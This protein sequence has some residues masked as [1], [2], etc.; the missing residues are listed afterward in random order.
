MEAVEQAIRDRYETLT[1]HLDE[2]ATRLFLGSEAKALGRGGA[3]AV[4][5]ATGASP[6]TVRRG[7]AELSGEL[8]LLDG[9]VR[10]PGAGRKKSEDVQEGLAQALD[11]LIEPT[12]RGDPES[13]L[14]WTSKSTRVLSG[15]LK[16]QGFTVSHE[17]VSQMLSKAGYSLQSNRKV[18]EGGDHPDR[19]LQFQKIQMEVA[20]FQEAGEPVISVDAKKK[21]LI[22]NYKN[23]GREWHPEGAAPEVG[24]YDFIGEQGKVTP[25][26]VYDV[27]QNDAWVNVGTD[28]DTASF[29]VASI[30]GWWGTMGR[31]AYPKATQLLINADG[32]GSNGS[33]NRMWKVELQKFADDS[34]LEIYV[35]HF[36][37]GTSKWNKIE[38]R[39][40]SRITQNWRGRPLVSHEVVVGLIGATTSRTG[41]R[42]TAELDKRSYPVGQKVPDAEMDALLL[43]RCGFH[44]EWNYALSPRTKTGS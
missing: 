32:G 9:R 31:A 11:K 22:G 29:A 35:C 18:L 7:L 5:R 3:E 36:P 38:H 12:T 30:R 15:E 33:R 34:G 6:R 23:A 13:P 4:V 2:R 21:E 19:D 1:P 44:G 8:P 28:H 37:P 17:K 20:S 26:G 10:N 42:V 43:S 27:T 24:V 16:K 14:R 40:F 39:L 25:Y 41:L